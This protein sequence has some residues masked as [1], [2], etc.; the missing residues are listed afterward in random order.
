MAPIMLFWK[1]P[2]LSEAYLP[3]HQRIVEAHALVRHAVM[4]LLLLH[5]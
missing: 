1:Q 5:S 2:P 4:L 3:Y